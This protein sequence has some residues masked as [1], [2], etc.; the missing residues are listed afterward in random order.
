MITLGA[1]LSCLTRLFNYFYFCAIAAGQRQ[2]KHPTLHSSYESF[3][4][5][6]ALFL[7]I[8]AFLTDTFVIRIQSIHFTV[9]AITALDWLLPAVRSNP[10]T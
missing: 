9:L 4:N 5:P 8:M 10:R 2:G 3:I 6:P 7:F 1:V